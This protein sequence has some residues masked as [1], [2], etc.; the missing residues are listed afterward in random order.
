MAV[1]VVFPDDDCGLCRNKAVVEFR[2]DRL[3]FGLVIPCPHCTNA[4]RMRELLEK[5][6]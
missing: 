4:R 6:T 1:R 3:P 5:K 2:V